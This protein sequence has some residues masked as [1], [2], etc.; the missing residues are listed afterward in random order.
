[1]MPS[2]NYIYIFSMSKFVYL[3]YI[4]CFSNTNGIFLIC[5]LQY[6]V[7]SISQNAFFR[8]MLSTSLK[9]ALFT[10]FIHFLLCLAPFV[11]GGGGPAEI[12]ASEEQRVESVL[13]P[14][15][16][17]SSHY[18]HQVPNPNPNPY[19]QWQPVAARPAGGHNPS[20]YG[21]TAVCFRN[22]NNEIHK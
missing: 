9:I 19:V 12:E 1:M 16:Y 15:A 2:Y 11:N 14:S 3:L 7:S 17:H 13:P 22:L 8:T 5:K 10:I 6:H 21:Q 4:Y 18:P 20:H